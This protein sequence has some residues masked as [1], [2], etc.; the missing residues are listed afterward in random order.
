MLVVGGGEDHD[1]RRRP[2]TEASEHL[3]AADI[4][5]TQVEHDAVGLLDLDHRQGVLARGGGQRLVATGTQIGG[6]DAQDREL[7]VDD[8]D[9][10]T[11]DPR[12]GTSR[13]D[14]APAGA[15]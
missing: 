7:V 8:Q 15:S 13:K 1:R 4:G 9:P 3:Q 10:V 6:N 5:Q 12:I 11:H 14:T 2:G